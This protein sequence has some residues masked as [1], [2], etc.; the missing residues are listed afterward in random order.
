MAARTILK[1]KNQS[2]STV[3]PFDFF[4]YLAV[5][6]YIYQNPTVTVSV[7]NGAD[8]NPSA[9]IST[10]GFTDTAATVEL[11]GG[12]VGVTYVV[13][14]SVNTTTAVPPASPTLYETLSMSGYLSVV[15]GLV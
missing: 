5:G 10:L 13:T 15:T 1:T 9:M 4:S 3:I 14:A 7:W 12:V 6:E 8:A 2:D 11:I